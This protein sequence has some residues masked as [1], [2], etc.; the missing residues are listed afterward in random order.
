MSFGLWRRR[1]NPKD[2]DLKR[3]RRGSL[4]NRY[5]EYTIHRSQHCT[6]SQP[7]DLDLKHHRRGSL[8][9]RTLT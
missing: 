3:H 4:R 7:E 8:K 6:A 1:Q 5:G 2:L 9:T